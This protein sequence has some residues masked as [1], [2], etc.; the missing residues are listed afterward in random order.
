MYIP[1]FN[2]IEDQ[3]TTLVFMRANPFAILVSNHENAPFA[4]HLPVLVA[5]SGE[6]LVI[7]AHVAKANPHW[8]MIEHQESLLIFHGPH[9]YISPALYEIRESVPTWNYATVHAYGRGKILPADTDK[10][11][12]LAEL[13]SQFDSSYLQQ[14]KSFDEQYRSRMLNHIVAFEIAVTRIESKFKLSQNRTR[15]EQENVI[16]AL[17][18]SSDPAVSGVADLMR[19]RG[20]GAK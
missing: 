11:E 8:K 16:Q 13:I 3:A 2:R 15:V 18:A 12:V 20:L 4:T 19:K 14:W 9:A 5:D 7:R 6:Q 1:E 17:G 10:H